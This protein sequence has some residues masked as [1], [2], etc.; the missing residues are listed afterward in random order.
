MIS[1]ILLS[2]KIPYE[3]WGQGLRLKMRERIWMDSVGTFHVE[4]K[5]GQLFMMRRANEVYLL[6]ASL[7]KYTTGAGFRN[8]SEVRSEMFRKMRPQGRTSWTLVQVHFAMQCERDSDGL[9]KTFQ[10]FFEIFSK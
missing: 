3:S 2:K 5:S 7:I 8:I 9:S 6:L 4:E 1:I 10:Y